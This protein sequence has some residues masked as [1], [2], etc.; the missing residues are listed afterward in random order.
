MGWMG[1]LLVCGCWGTAMAKN[2]RKKRRRQRGGQAAAP[3][4]QPVR[5][6]RVAPESRP[7]VVAARP[8]GPGAEG[9]VVGTV[10]EVEREILWL[11]VGG[12]R[13]MLYASELM[14]AVGERPSDRYAIGDR[15][16]AFVFQMDP[17]P[18][19]GAAQF[20]IRRASPY[21]E[22]LTDLEVGSEVQATVVNT[23]DVGIE[24]DVGG[25]RGN[26]FVQNLPLFV[27]ETT[28]QRYQPGDQ[29]TARIHGIDVKDREL[30]LAACQCAPGYVEA[31]QRRAVGEV[32]SG[33]VIGFWGNGSGVWL[34][35]DGLVGFVAPDELDLDDGD[36]A[37]DRYAVGD[38]ID[39]LVVWQVDHEAR[40]LDLS[41][42]RNAPGYLEALQ[43]RAVG[44]ILSG[45]ITEFQS[46]GGLW[47]D[48]GGLV[49][50]VAPHELDLD[51]G[52]FAQERYSVGETIDGLFVWQ[53][54]HEDRDLDLSVKRNAPG[55]L[56]ALEAIARGDEIDCL[57]TTANEWGVWLSAAG[58][59]G[60]IPASELLL[61]DGESPATRYAAGDKVTARVWE[62]DHEVCDIVLSVRRLESDFPEETIAKGA[63]IDAVVRGTPPRGTRSPIRVLAAGEEIWIPPHVLSLSTA[64]PPPFKDGQAIRVVVTDLDED[65]R[66]TKLSHRRT[67]ERWAAEV[68]R[69]TPGALVARS[70]V[71]PRGAIPDDEDQLAVDLG[72]ITGIIPADELDRDAAVNLMA[73]GANE[74]YPVVVESVNA[75]IGSTAIV[76][77]ERFEER[78]QEL[79]AG[80]EAGAEVDGE[81]REVEERVAVLDLGSGLL[82]EMPVEQLPARAEGVEA[83]QD[84]TGETV[85]VQIK[86]IEAET[87]TIA[88]EI[89][90]YDLVRMI[91]ADETLVC[92]LKEVFLKSV[93]PESSRARQNRQDVNRSVV[94][95]MAGMMNRDGGHVIVGVEDT[96]KKDGEV[97]GWEAS[98][99]ENQNAMA[100]GLS[101][102]VSNVLTQAAGK[103]F[104][105]R[106][107]M[108][109][110]GHEVLDIDCEPAAEPIFLIDGQRNEFPVRYPA[111]TKNLTARD[112]H[113][114]IQGRFYG[115][116]AAGV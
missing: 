115:R 89:R 68:G 1:G 85:T 74:V 111:M 104:E 54:D 72:A 106:F 59:V 52:E 4:P 109:P 55:Y 91:A 35:V 25:V 82:A 6:G 29:I 9:T 49:G 83:E 108:L 19:L 27:G 11:D 77:H 3:P 36:S 93:Q 79:A 65:D 40:I 94:R 46:N 44:E 101:E 73:F 62:I 43:Q 13:S 60:W 103:L 20:S 75:D 102:L 107:E 98:G 5:P 8:N 92:E 116:G 57:V 95:A 97:V 61:D 78:W 80:F 69:L 76:S 87:Y 51:D 81:L 10:V 38:H 58:V 42:K 26:I 24:L 100:T 63:V 110:D 31:L 45:T 47:L 7:D 23:Y 71:L 12:V 99:W 114:Y 50:F 2:R 33:T 70:R 105:P 17:D 18:D 56:E 22:G 66:P 15:L 96:D 86:S 88:V 16:E 39:G 34:D 112:Q 41:A 64:V 113:E 32:V 30:E 67:L 28:H 21:P 37:Q 53:V 14:L 90:N 48:V 84:R